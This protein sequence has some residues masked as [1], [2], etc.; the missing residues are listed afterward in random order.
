VVNRWGN[1]VF[2]TTDPNFRWDGRNISTNKLCPDGAYFYVCDVFEI[3]LEGTRQRTIT[4]SVHIIT[5][6]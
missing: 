3:T 5:G 4:G 6:K 1:L 2:E